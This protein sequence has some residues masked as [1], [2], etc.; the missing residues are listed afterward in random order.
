MFLCL[1]L[2]GGKGAGKCFMEY[3]RGWFC[4]YK[5]S[6]TRLTQS[7]TQNILF[8]FTLVLPVCQ[9]DYPRDQMNSEEV[10]SVH[11]C[12][13]ERAS[14]Y[15]KKPHVFR[16]QTADWRVFLFQAS[17]VTLKSD[18]CLC[19]GVWACR[20]NRAS[21]PPPTPPPSQIQDG[22]EFLDQPH[23][24]CF[25]SSFF[26]SVRRRRRLS[27]EVFQTD[28]PQLTVC[29]QSGKPQRWDIFSPCSEVFLKVLAQW[30]IE[31]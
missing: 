29:F 20:C 23:Q 30:T 26:A 22:D 6:V 21:V 5:R 13:A 16:L 9:N 28:P 17:W 7:A 2:R 4:T 15:T 19:Y 10:V 12:L 25:G 31:V 18:V 8:H 27:E 14:D 24:L 1:Q 3:W 11:H